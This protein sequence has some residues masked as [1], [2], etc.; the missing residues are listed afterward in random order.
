MYN[1][2]TQHLMRVYSQKAGLFIRF[3]LPEVLCFDFLLT[4]FEI[5]LGA[6]IKKWTS[7]THFFS[8]V[9]IYVSCQQGHSPL[10]KV[11]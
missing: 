9:H 10:K 6:P 2:F 7:V 5:F 1:V 3:Y 11:T 4:T 8:E